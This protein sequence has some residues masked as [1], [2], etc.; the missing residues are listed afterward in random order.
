[1]ETLNIYSTRQTKHLAEK[2]IKEIDRLRQNDAEFSGFEK[3]ELGECSIEVFANGELTCQYRNSIRDKRI[4][5]FGETGTNEIM[6]L[7]LMVDAAKRASAGKI[8][9]VIPSF[10]YARQDKKEGIR[11]PMGAKLVADLLSVAGIHGIITI[12]LHADSIQGFFN[13]P[14]NHINGFSI[15][16]EEIKKLVS[17]NPNNYVICSPDQGGSVRANRF[18]K[19]IGLDGAVAINKERDKPGS[20]SKM[21]LMADVANK[22][23]LLFDDMCDSAKTLCKAADYLI[24]EKGAR[25]V[26]AICTHP[27]FSGDAIERI[28]T[29]ETLSKLFIS[30][31]LNFEDKIFQFSDYW[32]K[33]GGGYFDTTK[34]Q[35]V[36]CSTILA[37]IIGRIAKGGSMDS[38]NG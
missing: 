31:T 4:Y 15:F 25:S 27:V 36:S 35:I 11:G 30:D 21:I 29:T 2:V 12:E 16:K 9:V 28:F 22:N 17:E 7:L 34:I 32:S 8:I 26:S 20:I 33:V 37:R 23:V 14:I 24:K 19:K 10:G 1:M 38:V 6:E 3:T 18:S 13:V 5:I